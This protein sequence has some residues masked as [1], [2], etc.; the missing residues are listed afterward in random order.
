M[1]D[2]NVTVAALEADVQLLF[3]YAKG[4]LADE[5]SIVRLIKFEKLF[6]DASMKHNRERL[7]RLI[8]KGERGSGFELKNTFQAFC[9]TN[10][11]WNDAQTSFVVFRDHPK[12]R[13]KNAFV[14]RV[15]VVCGRRTAARRFCF[16]G[17][18]SARSQPSGLCYMHAPIVL[19]HYLAQMNATDAVHMLDMA[20]YLRRHVSGKTLYEHV[21]NDA[22]GDS[23]YFLEK[24]LAPAPQFE[25][26]GSDGASWRAKLE[27]Y[28]PLLASAVEIEDAFMNNDATSFLTQMSTKSLGL[29]AMV[30]VGH[31]KEGD[32]NRFLLQ[33]WW[34]NK[35]RVAF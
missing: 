32:E 21:W 20:K 14:E 31:R 26:L 13:D 12:L 8:S 2:D 33:N 16:P 18:H 10:P 29:H 17:T 22:G 1:A 11:A 7:A 30:L 25:M 28:G 34:A 6:T 3:L 15:Q 23:L 24:I 19:Q 4:V 35:V 9:E 5:E 27:Q